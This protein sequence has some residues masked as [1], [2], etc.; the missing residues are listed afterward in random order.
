MTIIV[1]DN[2]STYNL[3]FNVA[4][5]DCGLGDAY[6]FRIR[7]QWDQTDDTWVG[8][9]TNGYFAATLLSTNDRYSEFQ[10]VLNAFFVNSKEHYNGIYEYELLCDD[11]SVLDS[12]LIKVVTNP[13]GTTGDTAFVS[14]NENLEADT[15]FT[16]NY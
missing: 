3:S 7:S 2:E 12:G 10:I 6:K 13:G 8:A 9:T 1:L 5:V 14:N 4:N 15:Y 16:P 11:E